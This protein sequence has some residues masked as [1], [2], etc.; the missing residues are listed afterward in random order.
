MKYDYAYYKERV[1]VIDAAIH[2]GYKYDPSKGRLKK[3]S[4]THNKQKEY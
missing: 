2:I 4:K 3:G 1:G